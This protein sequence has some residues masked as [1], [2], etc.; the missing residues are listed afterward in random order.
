MH[1]HQRECRKLA[2]FCQHANTCTP[3]Y[4]MEQHYL[5]LTLRF[6]KAVDPLLFAGYVDFL[7]AHD[8]AIKALY[9]LSINNE[10]SDLARRIN[11]ERCFSRIED[12]LLKAN[13][14]N[15]YEC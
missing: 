3:V 6:G 11:R 1:E 4:L 14:R 7:L 10:L 12:Y 5:N 8:Q 15:T 2:C 9:Y 13:S